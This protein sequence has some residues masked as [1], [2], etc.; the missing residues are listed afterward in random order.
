MRLASSLPGEGEKASS[1]KTSVELLVTSLSSPASGVIVRSLGL[2]YCEGSPDTSPEDSLGSIPLN[3]L[4]SIPVDCL[5]SIPVAATDT[6]EAVVEPLLPGIEE[7]MEDSGKAAVSLVTV[8]TV[9]RCGGSDWVR[10]VMAGEVL[11]AGTSPGRLPRVDEAVETFPRSS[12][13]IWKVA[14]KGVWT[15]TIGVRLSIPPALPMGADVTGGARWER[16]SVG[17]CG[18]L[19]NAE[20]VSAT[21]VVSSSS[22]PPGR[23]WLY[24]AVSS[25]C[26]L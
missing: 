16:T 14:G 10:E 1:G 15:V 21:M 24:C 18:G 13:G 3:S 17:P 23:F 20:L 11:E 4:G 26:G 25:S 2:R 12:L 19:M 22:S 8:E 7:A 6:L 9:D 5:E